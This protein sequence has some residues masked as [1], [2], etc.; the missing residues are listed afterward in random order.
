MNVTSFA[1][2]EAMKLW[3]KD[4]APNSK[5]LVARLTTRVN[6]KLITFE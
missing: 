5:R 6:T 4:A 1:L 3:R 2:E